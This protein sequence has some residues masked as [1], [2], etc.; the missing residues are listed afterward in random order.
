MARRRRLG[1]LRRCFTRA[2]VSL[3]CAAVVCLAATAAPAAAQ[4]DDLRASLDEVAA[5]PEQP[6]IVSAGGITR[7]QTALL[8]LENPTPFSEDAARRRLVLVGGLDGSVDGARAVVEAVRW[9]KIEAS[10]AARE[11]WVI[12]AMPLV[13]PDGTGL[14]A[15]EPFPPEEGYY[16][17]ADRPEA[18]YAWR[19]VT[20]QAPD[21]VLVVGAG[22]AAADSIERT[23]ADA[24]V[25]HPGNPELGPVPARAVVPANL[26]A[27]VRALV[28]A[29]L[30]AVSPLRR[31]IEQR[32]ARAPL[33]IARLLAARYPGRP[34]MSYIPG[35]AWV[36]TLRFARLTGE[37]G[38][39]DKVLAEVRP[40]LSGD[41]PL[42]GERI[43]F[44]SL[45]GAMVFA[46]L[47]SEGGV[48]AAVASE[49]AA[50]AAEIA[51]SETAPG[52]PEHGSG[53]TDDM[54]LGTVVASLARDPE[55]MSVSARLITR[56]A[57]LLQQDD[58]I[59]NHAPDAPA[60][61]SRGNGFAGLG[62]AELLTALPTTHPGRPAVLDVFRRQ[63]EGLREHQ[64]P[65]GMWFQ[66]VDTPGSY[67]E[68]SLT[69]LAATAMARGVRLGWLDDS[70]R[71]VIQRAWSALLAHVELDGEL[72]DVCISTGAGPTRRY[73]LDRPAVNGPDDRGGALILGAALEVHALGLR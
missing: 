8:T 61:W 56:Y 19:W 20:Y 29:P 27:E 53:W 36:H 72:V 65:D 21:A 41:E 33:D 70:Y 50:R 60:P 10:E 32:I 44:A 3:A 13:D 48:E 67:R 4:V 18:H 39:R 49:L 17:D 9:F 37:T 57:G 47:A 69:A 35:A 24:L 63:M 26:P 15:T 52:T 54:Y 68:G 45:G 2:V 25:S 38:W 12:S 59:F 51:R 7:D 14:D 16:D 55:G 66:V 73:Y 62:M 71:T 6:A 64:A 40:W 11:G 23:L 5:L 28:E 42:T 43:S 31:S 1:S 46:E 22:A 34:S 30:P 58:G